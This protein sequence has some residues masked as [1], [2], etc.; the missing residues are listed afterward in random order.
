MGMGSA[1]E[2]R[3]A[4]DVKAVLQS[5]ISQ[6][7]ETTSNMSTEAVVSLLSALGEVSSRCLPT[8]ATVAEPRLSALARMV[9]TL[10]YNLWRVHDLWGIFLAHLME[11]LRSANPQVGGVGGRHFIFSMEGMV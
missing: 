3:P 10:L 1:S 4:H 5:A 9:D 2:G 8:Q 11:V 6:L 7:F